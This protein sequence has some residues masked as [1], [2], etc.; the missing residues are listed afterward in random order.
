MPGATLSEQILARNSGQARVRP[1]QVVDAAV[2]LALSHDNSLLVS[3]Q[4]RQIGLPRVWDPAKCVVTF[5]HRGPA[6][7]IEVADGHREVREFLKAQ[8]ITKFYD[9]GYGICHQVL[10]EEGLVRPGMVLVGTD[11][12]TTTHGAFGAFSLGIGATEMAGVWATGRLWFRVPETVRIEMTGRLQRRVYTKD[13]ILRL[14]GDHGLDGFDYRTVEFTGSLFDSL[15]VDSRMTIA[16]LAMEMGAKNAFCP[17]DEAVLS[18]LKRTT[19]GPLDPI[20]P[21]P[22]AAY[23]RRLAVDVSGLEPQVACPNAVDNVKPVHEVAGTRV[24]QV[25]IGTCTN[26][27]LED[28]QQAAEVLRGERIAPGI[29]VM[30]VP[31]SQKVFLQALKDGTV[32][33]LTEAGVSFQT[34]GC[35]P[36]LGAHQGLLGKGEV[37]FS[38]TNRN[39]Q[40]RMGH[41]DSQVYLGSPA[42]AAAT[43]LYGVITDPRD[44]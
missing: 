29:R 28:F 17:V 2:D 22:D 14:I 7:T 37:C 20:A 1:G 44:S 8:G 38:T 16:N 43:A 24:D 34:A 13:L 3:R 5:D 36:C 30:A 40:G 27:R 41:R 32:Q 4:F 15:T 25:F 11:S 18:W 6:A 26:G 9:V 31:A 23:E 35:G 42:T 33:A 19:P 39:F 21:D 12:H 10:P